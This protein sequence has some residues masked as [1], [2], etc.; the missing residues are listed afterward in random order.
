MIDI[1][2]NPESHFPQDDPKGRQQ[3]RSRRT[4]RRRTLSGTLRTCSR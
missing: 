2:W 3:G 4:G 1:W